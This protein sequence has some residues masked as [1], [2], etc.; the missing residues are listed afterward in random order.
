[1]L[2][3]RNRKRDIGTLPIP[4]FRSS[5]DYCRKLFTTLLILQVKFHQMITMDKFSISS[6]KI[7]RK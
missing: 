2:Q 5:R 7:F 4:L 3:K 1:M 6:I